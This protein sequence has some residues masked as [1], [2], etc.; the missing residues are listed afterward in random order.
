MQQDRFIPTLPDTDRP[1]AA[2]TIKPLVTAIFSATL[3]LQGTLVAPLFFSRACAWADGG[4]Q[5][6]T[7]PAGPLGQALG[8][9]ASQAGVVLSFDASLTEG[10]RSSGL[11]GRYDT[12]TGFARLL[13]GSGLN[14]RFIDEK[15]VRL[16][17]SAEINSAINLDAMTVVDNQLGTI[18]ENTKSYTP[19]V[20]ASAT[21]LVLTPRETPQSV[22]VITR[23]HMDDFN[24]TSIDKVM[25]HTPGVTVTTYDSDRSEYYARGFPITNFQYDGIPI[26]RNPAYSSGNTMSDMIAY[27]RI[28]IIKGAS[29]L[30]TGAGSPG[31]T[32]NLVRKKPTA[33]FSGHAT[34]EAGRWDNYR[35]QWDIG[36][37]LNEEGN[38][39]GRVVGAFQDRQ[40]FQDHYKRQ[41]R[42]YY[43]ILEVDLAPETLLTFG[44]DYNKTIPTGSSWGG[45][46]IFDSNNKEIHVSRSFNPGADWSAYEQYSHSF[47]TQL[48]HH[49]DNG[50]VSRAYYTY[51]VNGYDAQLGSIYYSPNANTGTATLG[52]GKYTGKAKSHAL[53]V[54]ASGPFELFGREHELVIGASAYRNHW[55]GNDFNFRSPTVDNFY[56][57][58][59]DIQKPDW[60]QVRTRNDRLTNQ[61]A[62]YATVRFKPTDDLALILGSRVTNYHMT[63]DYNVRNTGEVTPFAGMV[64][65]L[66]DNFSAYAS[67]TEIFS[68]TTFIYSDANGNLLPLEK[69][70]SY[71]AGIKGEWFNGRLNASL[72][73]FEIREDNRAEETGYDYVNYRS[74]Y[75]AVKAK[76]KGIELEVSGELAP[77]WNI[78]AGYTH[79]V[80]RRDKDNHKLSTEE[81]ENLFKLYTTY[82]L[83]GKL[84]K[85]TIG[86]G[87]N[88][89]GT[90]WRDIYNYSYDLVQHRQEAFWLVNLMGKYQVTDKLS[91][92]LNINNLFDKYYYS[93]IGFGSNATQS[94]GDPRNMM[95]TTR[96]DF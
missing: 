10:K 11:Q 56:N 7:I 40:S 37:P 38:I 44:A 43:G 71:E 26:I 76:T 27:D 5:T 4:E 69:G 49:F 80:I 31:A 82:R 89:Q 90:T 19:G 18:T 13:E 6:F 34:A 79:K 39:R 68:P 64:Y 15:T 12:A 36:G 84:N 50:W 25:E 8:R 23:Q 45:V 24:L 28:E 54:Y 72:A 48:D 88:Y 33:E 74:I 35:T 92:T 20:I 46:P 91:A 83:P 3:A 87:A 85:L 53:E 61:R 65:D 47:F 62:V 95:L 94:Y 32:L 52:S 21:R 14:A 1:R 22:T 67:Y 66:N 75:E 57:W 70:D 2:R 60:G 51:Q 29:G 73:Y 86:G 42:A 59:G 96:W 17:K 55:K 78:Q 16:E 93:N 77:G 58:S 63:R 81:P 30:T 9:Y 41:T